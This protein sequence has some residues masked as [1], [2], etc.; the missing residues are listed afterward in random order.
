MKQGYLLAVDVGGTKTD[1]VLAAAGHDRPGIIAQQVYASQEFEALEAVIA[2]FLARREAQECAGAL[3]AICVSVAGPVEGDHAST[4]NLEWK[5]SA[6]ALSERFAAPAVRLINDFAAAGIGISRLDESD[7]ETL[8]QGRPATHG[9]RAIIGA[10]TGLGVAL[11]T[12]NGRSY[13]VHASE[14]G[15]ADFAPLDEVQDG[16]LA[17]LR[18]AYGRVSYERVLSGPGL[19]QIFHY[20]KES[21]FETPSPALQ[22]AAAEEP[23]TAAVISE[24]G[25]AQRDPLAVRALN[26]FATVYGAFAGNVALTVLARGGVYIAGG[27]APKLVGKLKDGIFVRA[28]TR[29]GRFGDL[30]KTVPVR[31]VM[32]P[33]V[34]LYGALE[35]AGQLAGL[36]KARSGKRKT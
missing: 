19:A 26:L 36:G 8:Q 34:G 28:F 7:F 17:Y 33:R 14:A 3:A 10:G 6:G 24:F 27:I 22:E 31:V 25:L 12:W 2:E 29:K 30:L 5:I 18:R 32:N 35:L 20:L 4:T 23:D 1:V 11:M 16:L 15:H 21:G 13:A 9:A